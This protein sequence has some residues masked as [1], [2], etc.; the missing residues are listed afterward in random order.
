VGLRRGRVFAD[1]WNLEAFSD[2]AECFIARRERLRM[3]N[4]SQAAQPPV[5]CLQCESRS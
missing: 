2:C 4:H 5:D 3:M 1:L